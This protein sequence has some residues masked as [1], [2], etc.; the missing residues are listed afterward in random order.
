MSRRPPDLPH[1][2]PFRFVARGFLGPTF[3][4]TTGETNAESVSL[5][6]LAEAMAQAI[7]VVDPPENTRGLRLVGLD[8]VILRQE[9]QPGDQ[10]DIEVVRHGHFARLARFQCRMLRGGSVV[11]E[12]M[13]TVGH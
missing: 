3:A 13:I 5:A 6:I 8:Q 12:G 4:S 9:V 10:L 2:P 11:A 1:H 7:L